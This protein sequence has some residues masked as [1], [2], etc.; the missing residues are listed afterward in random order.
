M[1]HYWLTFY[2]QSTKTVVTR[3]SDTDIIT[4]YYCTVWNKLLH[5]LLEL[6]RIKQDGF[7][8]S[9]KVFVRLL[10][11]GAVFLVKIYLSIL[12]EGHP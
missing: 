4:A 9:V 5:N 8:P 3:S 1:M 6:T 10:R 11:K 2:K 7:V 12:T